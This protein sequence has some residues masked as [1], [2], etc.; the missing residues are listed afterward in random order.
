MLVRSQVSYGFLKAVRSGSMRRRWPKVRRSC[1]GPSCGSTA[2][3][4]EPHHLR[5]QRSQPADG[6]RSARKTGAEL[7]HCREPRPPEK[8]RQSPREAD[9]RRR[10]LT[11]P[12]PREV[13]PRHRSPALGPTEGDKK[14]AGRG[15]AAAKSGCKPGRALGRTG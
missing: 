6:A 11:R 1:N 12:P 15:V 10:R 14:G 2:T 8:W 4:R 3:G 5:A 9:D 7:A 13:S